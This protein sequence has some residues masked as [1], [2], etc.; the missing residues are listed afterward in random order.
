MSEREALLEVSHLTKT[1]KLRSGG[2]APAKRVQAVSDVSLSIRRGETFGLVG[3]SGC[4]KSTLGRAIL[5]ICEPDSGRILFDG[6]DITR[7]GAAEMRP[8]RRRMQMIFQDPYAS[9]N[10]RFTVGDT[11]REPMEIHRL[12]DRKEGEARV[13]ALL[14]TVGLKSDHIQRYPHEFSGGQRQRIGIMRALAPEPEF[15]VC[16]EPFSAL[17]VSIQ[18]QIINL[19]ERIQDEKNLAYLLITHNLAAVRHISHQVGVMYLG[20]LVEC[21]PAQEVC[22]HPA[23]PYTQALIASVPVLDPHQA[24]RARAPLEGEA[25][26]PIDIPPGC[27][28]AGRC[29]YCAAKCQEAAP[30]LKWI[31]GRQVACH[32]L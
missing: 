23:H 14:E 15:I 5:R 1:F 6:A 8:F 19:L 32:L 28:F 13:R 17:D 2:F 9:L 11:V 24:D 27:A 20:R 21:G 16:D 30:E 4:G 31:D 7:L 3:E 22:D 29:R 26:S 12:C 18:A 10:P 25:I